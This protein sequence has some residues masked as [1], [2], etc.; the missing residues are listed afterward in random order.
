MSAWDGLRYFI[1]ALPE[2][3]YFTAFKNRCILHRH[4]G[5][6]FTSPFPAFNDSFF[7]GGM[8]LQPLTLIYIVFCKE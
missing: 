3:N 5:A 2:N 4:N 1:V 6:V 8:F 7:L